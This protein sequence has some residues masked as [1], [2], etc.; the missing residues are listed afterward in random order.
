MKIKE[1]IFNRSI[2]C[3]FS[4]SNDWETAHYTRTF[5]INERVDGVKPC[6]STGIM[7]ARPIKRADLI[8]KQHMRKK[9]MG[10]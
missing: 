4:N 9:M 6:Y 10:L 8:R 7:M 5:I 2:Q 3:L 1:K